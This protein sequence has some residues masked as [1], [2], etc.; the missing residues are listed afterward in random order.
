MMTS[1][2]LVAQKINGGTPSP[3]CKVVCIR[4]SNVENLLKQILEH[5]KPSGSLDKLS[6][7]LTH[8]SIEHGYMMIMIIMMKTVYF[9]INTFAK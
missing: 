3:C 6:G 7:C 9:Y 4:P 8:D 2:V 1:L 5:C